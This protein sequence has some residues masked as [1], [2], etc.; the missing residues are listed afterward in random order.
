MN[1]FAF[2]TFGCFLLNT[3]ENAEDLQSH[4]PISL[5]WFTEDTIF[6]FSCGSLEVR[7]M[8]QALVSTVF[9]WFTTHLRIAP[10]YPLGG[11]TPSFVSLRSSLGT[12]IL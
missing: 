9:P 12:I 8:Y 11:C 2:G 6:A 1:G 3:E 4:P 5:A 7:P 10:T